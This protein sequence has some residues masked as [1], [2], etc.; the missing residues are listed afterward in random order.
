MS[1]GLGG[2]DAIM[3]QAQALQE[4]L[5]RIQ[6]DAAART[7]E[8]SGIR[9]DHPAR[10]AEFGATAARRCASSRTAWHVLGSSEQS[11]SEDSLPSP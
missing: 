11:G 4:R 10:R 7:V 3:K 8:R 6:E 1:K 2:F 9:S 5:G